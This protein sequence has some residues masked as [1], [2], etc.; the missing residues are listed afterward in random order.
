MNISLMQAGRPPY[1][2]FEQRAEE[3]RN[4]TVKAGTLVLKDVDYAII[5][6]AGS[7]DT[8]EKVAS[9]WLDHCGF[10]STKGRWP[11]EWVVAHRKMYTDWKAGLEATPFGFPIRQWPSISKAQ[12]E[13]LALASVLTVEDLAASNEQTMAKIGM[14]ARALK[15]KA[16]AWLDASKGNVGEELAALR[17]QVSD[18]VATVGGMREKNSEL[19][20]ALQSQAKKRA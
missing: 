3:D 10:E 8:V 20:S 13:N 9:E 11:A 17:A 1:V 7:K 12:A 4:A 15:E 2:T 19:E 14:G 18:L 6:T 5:R 16:Q